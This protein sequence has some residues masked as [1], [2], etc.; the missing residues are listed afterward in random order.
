MD[1]SPSSDLSLALRVCCKLAYRLLRLLSIWYTNRPT[2]SHRLPPSPPRDP[3]SGLILVSP[4]SF[5]P[6]YPNSLLS[7]L[8]SYLPSPSGAFKRHWI[9]SFTNWEKGRRK[10]GFGSQVTSVLVAKEPL[11]FSTLSTFIL[12]KIEDN[13]LFRYSRET[14]EN[15]KRRICWALAENQTKWGTASFLLIYIWGGVKLQ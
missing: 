13:D 4:V 1:R 6:L 2:P 3:F 5:G 10:W 8:D 15:G 7:S 12:R 9:L 11:C 14:K